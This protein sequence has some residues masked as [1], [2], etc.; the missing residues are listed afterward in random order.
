[1]DVSETFGPVD[2]T[3][4]GTV[5]AIE[6]SHAVMQTVLLLETHRHS[7]GQSE[8]LYSPPP[9]SGQHSYMQNKCMHMQKANTPTHTYT[10]AG[11]WGGWMGG[12]VGGE[13]EREREKRRRRGD[14]VA[15]DCISSSS[16]WG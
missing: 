13:G 14:L 12:W 6:S 8:A 16:K 5:G 4:S 11:I 15:V 7:D 9:R 3:I 10:W 2:T 1:M